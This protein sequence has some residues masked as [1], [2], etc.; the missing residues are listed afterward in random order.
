M[1]MYMDLPM[2]IELEKGKKG[3]HVLKLL[4]NLYGQKQAAH[5]WNK[6]LV[7]KLLP[8][9]FSHKSMNVSYCDSMIFIVNVDDGLFL[10]PSDGKPEAMIKALQETCFD[11]K[12][13]SVNIKSTMMDLMN[14][15][16]W[17]SFT[18]FW[19]MLASTNQEKSMSSPKHLHAHAES[20]PFYECDR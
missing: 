14:S 17:L 12:D 20:K 15:P 9:G 11:I 7:D 3:E 1:D 10:G 19:M 5:I 13:H 18:Q 8:V 6:Y 2:G 16:S 4:T